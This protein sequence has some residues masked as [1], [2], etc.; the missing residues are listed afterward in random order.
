MSDPSLSQ[1]VRAG[2]ERQL[3]EVH[4]VLPAKVSLYNPVLN[5]VDCEVTVIPPGAEPW[6]P[7]IE[8]PVAWPRGGAFG[9]HM[10]LAAGD[11]VWVFFAERDFSAWRVSGAKGFPAY[12][13]PLGVYP[14][15]IPGAAP[16]TNPL[17]TSETSDAVFGAFPVGPR[18]KVTSTGIEIGLVGTP[19]DYVVLSTLL[20]TVLGVLKTALSTPASCAAPSSPCP[21]QVAVA[22]AIAAWPGPFAAAVTKAT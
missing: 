22:A 18:V 10:P 17:L 14:F 12:E 9:L 3:D 21:Y 1:I 6:P 11:H 2:I 4:T 20:T 19:A 8:V 16:L 5:T 15:A 13:R 7:L